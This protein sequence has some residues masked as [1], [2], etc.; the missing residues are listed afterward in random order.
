MELMSLTV[1]PRSATGKGAARKLRRDGLVPAICYGLKKE[2]LHLSVVPKA[3]MKV[4]KG[5]L[6]RNAVFNLAVENDKVPRKVILQ[7]L[8]IHPLR[9]AVE[10][11]DFLEVTDD[12]K[13]VL[14]VPVVVEGR[15]LGEKAG[16]RLRQ[17]LKELRV[18]CRPPTVPAAITIDVSPLDI[19]AVLY[20]EDVQF[21]EGVESAMRGRVPVV[22]VRLGRAA[23]EGEGAEGAA[24]A[25]AAEAAPA[26]DA[27]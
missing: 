13:L 26:E 23:E 21:P 18:V 16:G 3:L 20:V 11:A 7:D 19:G 14:D 10:H 9:R 5:P 24:P 12:S 17:V 22:T 25:A 15:S 2:P 8:Q 4:L 1:T 6:G 27:D